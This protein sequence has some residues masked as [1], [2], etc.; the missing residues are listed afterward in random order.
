[1]ED[2][3]NS[4]NQKDNQQEQ[5][6]LLNQ[7]RVYD[8]SVEQAYR[9]ASDKQNPTPPLVFNVH[10]R[11][12]RNCHDDQGDDFIAPCN[13]SGSIQWVHR[14]CLDEWRS[15][16]PNPQ[17]FYRCDVCHYAYEFREVEEQNGGSCSSSNLKIHLLIIRDILFGIF[18]WQSIVWG[19][20]GIMYATEFHAFA[21]DMFDWHWPD[22]AIDYIGG[23][24]GF[25][26]LVGIMFFL[27][28]LF[29]SCP[30]CCCHSTSPDLSYDTYHYN[31]W[32]L[33]WEWSII[34]RII[35][36][37]TLISCHSMQHCRSNDAR[38]CLII[39]LIFAA[40]G[41]IVCFFMCFYFVYKI[42]SQRFQINSN[43]VKTRDFIVVDRA[44]NLV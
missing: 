32:F 43:R 1:M 39:T 33:W 23:L 41:F 38:V 9:E 11:V 17:S 26:C 7:A 15:V 14:K 31:S 6:P 30:C 12:C 4:I 22:L 13:C 8:P 27:I 34:T 25:F 42:Y 16:S 28:M 10:D 35:I 5:F 44:E 36:D 29:A 21:S 2:F 24:V 20:A 18:I 40:I 37:C 3:K 19:I